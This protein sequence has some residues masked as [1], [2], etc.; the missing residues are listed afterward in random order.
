MPDIDLDQ[1]EEEVASASKKR[2]AVTFKGKRYTL[3]KTLPMLFGLALRPDGEGNIGIE[4]IRKSLVSVLGEEQT[5]ALLL[6][7]LSLDAFPRLVGAIGAQYGTPDVGES[8]ASRS[9]SRRTSGRSRPTSNG[10][11]S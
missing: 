9:S 6:A 10:S 1:I 8:S 5:D 7:G 3:P 4:A 11:T 2:K